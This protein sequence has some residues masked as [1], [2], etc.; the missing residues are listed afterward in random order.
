ML[1]PL[2]CFLTF[3]LAFFLFQTR[4]S[5]QTFPLLAAGWSIKSLFIFKGVIL[6]IGIRPVTRSERRFRITSQTL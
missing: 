5:G 6:R 2:H 3:T 4:G 1:K